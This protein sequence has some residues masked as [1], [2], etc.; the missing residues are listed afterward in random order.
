MINK[1]E[2]LSRWIK[3]QKDDKLSYLL[4]EEGIMGNYPKFED[5][6]VKKSISEI[7]T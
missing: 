2:S 7:Q 3:R 1:E 4:E 6:K 5:D